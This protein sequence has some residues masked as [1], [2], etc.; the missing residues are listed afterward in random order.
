M[1]GKRDKLSQGLYLG[2]GR[3]P[4]GYTKEGRKRDTLLVI[5]EEQ[6]KVIR[7]IFT[8]YAVDRLNASKIVERVDTDRFA[9][10]KKRLDEGKFLSPRNTKNQYLMAKKLR[11]QRCGYLIEPTQ[12]K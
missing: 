11:C 3:P 8:W 4:Y 5:C 12:L 9:L 6:A 7:Q 10:A 2:T 1:R